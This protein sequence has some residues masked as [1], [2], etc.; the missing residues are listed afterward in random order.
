[1]KKRLNNRRLTENIIRIILNYAVLSHTNSGIFFLLLHVTKSI[2]GVHLTLPL[3]RL[4]SRQVLMKADT[5]SVQDG[6]STRHLTAIL[7][8]YLPPL[9][10]I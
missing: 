6:D 10:I 8:I 2:V 1:M 7:E 5:P 3:L 4:S 9:E